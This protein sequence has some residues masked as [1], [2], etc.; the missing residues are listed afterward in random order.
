MIVTRTNGTE[1]VFILQDENK[2]SIVLKA[3]V[4]PVKS[5]FASA[6]MSALGCRVP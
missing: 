1:G 4:N 2:N 6:F 3:M 5:F